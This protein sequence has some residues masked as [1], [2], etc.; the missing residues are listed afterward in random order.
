[1]GQDG[2]ESVLLQQQTGLTFLSQKKFLI[3]FL[4]SWANGDFC[5]LCSILFIMLYTLISLD[6][7]DWTLPHFEITLE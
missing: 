3:Y 7:A 5:V 4:I 2:P 1:M 6:D